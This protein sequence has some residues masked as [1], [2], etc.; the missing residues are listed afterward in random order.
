MEQI[1]QWDKDLFTYLNSLG[2]A[3]YD[4]FWLVVTHIQNWIPLYLLFF[5]LFWKMLSR[6]KA[7]FALIGTLAS[8]FTALVLT[9]IVKNTVGRLR[10]NNTPE[11]E[12]I[13]RVLQTPADY[14]FWSGHAATSFAVT[15]FVIA[16]LRTKS[17]WIYLALVWPILF[18]LSRIFVG[19]HFPSDLLAG[20]IVGITIA[21][22]FY[23]IYK[24]RIAL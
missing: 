3:S 2:S 8:L 1:A 11:L 20:A 13:I 19:V 23:S 21:T 4:G 15:F 22:L 24:K 17:R 18:T 9:S 7:I 6:K 14:S 5:I 12:G 10:P 16:I